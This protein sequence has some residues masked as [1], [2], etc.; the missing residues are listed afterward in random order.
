MGENWN[1]VENLRFSLVR[2]VDV[3][4]E[5]SSVDREPQICQGRGGWNDVCDE[6]VDVYRGAR[7]RERDDSIC[8]RVVSAVV[9]GLVEGR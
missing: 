2:D 6:I 8:P 4:L 9:P 7:E 1:G 3:L 5:M